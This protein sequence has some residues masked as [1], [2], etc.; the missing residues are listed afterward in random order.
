MINNVPQTNRERVRCGYLRQRHNLK[1]PDTSRRA[2]L[3]IKQRKTV[4]CEKDQLSN[5]IQNRNTGC[6][7]MSPS[8][9]LFLVIKHLKINNENEYGELN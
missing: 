8:L 7:M 5:I 3:K 4:L 6:Q 2:E 9:M 1:I